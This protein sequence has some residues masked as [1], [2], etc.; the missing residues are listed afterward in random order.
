MKF[1]ETEQDTWTGESENLLSVHVSEVHIF[2]SKTNKVSKLYGVDA[3]GYD[4][5][6]MDYK[7]AN[8]L[9]KSFPTHEKARVFAKK[10]VKL[11]EE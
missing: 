7:P 10:L 8:I 6:S 4:S 3:L 5:A 11:I 1:K 9:I 2:N